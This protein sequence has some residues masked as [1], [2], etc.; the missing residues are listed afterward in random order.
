[1]TSSSRIPDEVS[2]PRRRDA[3]ANRDRLLTEARSLFAR[4]GVD[5]S[6]EEIARRAD[7][8]VAT[9]YR[10]FPARD[11]LI[12]SLYDLSLSELASVR[13]EI[14]AAATAWEGVV[15]Y[16]ERVAEWLVADPSL[17][18]ILKRMA[19]IDPTYR[20]EAHF[21]SFIATLVKQAKADGDLRPD[22]EAVDVAVLVTLIGSLNALGDGYAGQW[23]RQLSILLDGLRT[24]GQ[25]RTKLPGRPLNMKVYQATM[26][27][28]GRR[29]RRNAT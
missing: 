12:R 28:L 3:R 5:A 6:L 11:D 13:E 26:H 17:P 16:M 27:G 7:V 2:P 24:P 22:V 4:D 8:G 25:E 14:E 18:P 1:M 9:L 29:A 23:R 10:N 21:E 19:V 20:P 15:T